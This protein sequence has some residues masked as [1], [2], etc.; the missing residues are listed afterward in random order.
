MDY[1]CSQLSG[2]INMGCRRNICMMECVCMY[3]YVCV[4]EA[5]VQYLMWGMCSAVIIKA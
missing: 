2:I 3:V 4:Y 1:G 5:L